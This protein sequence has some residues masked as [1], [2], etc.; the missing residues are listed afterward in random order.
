MYDLSPVTLVLKLV[1]NLQKDAE[2]QLP[3]IDNKEGVL[4]T[5]TDYETMKQWLF[6]YKWVHII[7]SIYFLRQMNYFLSLPE[8]IQQGH[9][10]SKERER[11]ATI[12]GV[13]GEP[14]Q[15]S[16]SDYITLP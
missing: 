9:P 7:T 8:Y 13:L 12:W 4:L 6:R 10:D 1:A 15:T 5:V 3:R 16:P 14:R 11:E 2:A